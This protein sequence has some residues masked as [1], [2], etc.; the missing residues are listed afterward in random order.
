LL[1]TIESI[2][3]CEMIPKHVTCSLK[4]PDAVLLRYAAIIPKPLCSLFAVCF[5]SFPITSVS[6]GGY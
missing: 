4:I 2:Y 5:H 1:F 3:N 6:K